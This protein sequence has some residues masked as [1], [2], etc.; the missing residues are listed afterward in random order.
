VS[1]EI[2]LTFMA[3]AAVPTRSDLAAKLQVLLNLTSAPDIVVLARSDDGHLVFAFT[4]MNPDA[5]AERLLQLPATTLQ[6]KLGVSAAAP[7]GQPASPSPAPEGGH[8]V[9]LIAG[10]G[11]AAALAVLFLIVIVMKRKAIC[12]GPP[13]QELR[14]VSSGRELS[15][16]GLDYQRLDAV[17]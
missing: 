3:G 11:V 14:V 17:N 6:S 2:E 15:G 10:V 16:R 4:G 5:L 13:E 12:Y 9:G 8:D 7:K 1:F